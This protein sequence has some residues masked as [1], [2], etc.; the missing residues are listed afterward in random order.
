MGKSVAFHNLGCKVNSY[1]TEKMMK[2]LA[3][4]GYII[5]PFDQKADIYVVNTCSVTNIADR[6]SRQMIHRA[7]SVNPDAVIVAAGCYVDTHA[8]ADTKTEGVDICVSNAEKKNVALIL[9]NY[10]SDKNY[11]GGAGEVS[12]CNG[13]GLDGVLHT[14]CFIKVQDGCDQFCSYCII[15][16]ARGRIHSRPVSEITDEIKGYVQKGYGEFVPTGIHISSYGKDRPEAGEDL[17]GLIQSISE[18]EGVKRIR[19]SSLEPKLITREFV[20]SLS[21]IRQ[22]CPHFHL[23]LQS[24][25]DGVLKR[26]NRHYT[27]EEYASAVDVI[28]EY[29]SDPAI[30]TDIITGFPGETEEEFEETIAFADRMDFYEMHVFKYSR[31]RGTAADKMSGQITE[32]VKHERSSRLLYLNKTK[33]RE[34]E[35]RH[36]MNGKL[37][38]VLFED[39]EEVRGKQFRTGYTREYI[40]VYDESGKYHA[41]D[42]VNGTMERQGDL[43]IFK[44]K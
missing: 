19:L 34:F 24:G 27:S 16:Y 9:D 10:F 8:E 39:M 18:V 32:E 31:R 13:S 5:V 28:R 12:V 1:E 35:D 22:I 37:P 38:E 25:S 11:S 14:R 23:S 29:F 3:E 33:K 43:I 7:R 20:S 2:E 30:T 15:P 6:K 4:N 17:P 40:K 42:I 44:G 41:G 21:R 36:I 26:M